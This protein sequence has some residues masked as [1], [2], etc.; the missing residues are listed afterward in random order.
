MDLENNKCIFSGLKFNTT[1]YNHDVSLF[2]KNL[3][4][5]IPY[6]YNTLSLLK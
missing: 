3:A 1:S 6:N 4:L 5:K 2:Y